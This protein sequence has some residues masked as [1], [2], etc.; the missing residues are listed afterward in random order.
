M[1]VDQ[2]FNYPLNIVLEVC[3]LPKETEWVEF[4]ENKADPEEIG[5]YISAL[6]NSAALA[7]KS[8]AY[9]VWGIEDITH[10]VVGTEFSPST[11]KVGN[12]ELESWLLRLLN[13]RI[14]FQFFEIEIEEKPVVLLEIE[15]A[16]RHPVQFKGMEYVR[17]GS[18]RKTLKDYPS[19]ERKL[20]RIFDQLSFEELVAKKERTGEEVL[21]LLDY[22]AYFSL[23][24]R[25]FPEAQKGVLETLASDGLIKNSD[26]GNWDIT[27]LGAILFAQRLSDFPLLR[28]KA[29]RVIHYR[30]S[31]RIETII[32]R[33]GEK[34]YA[35]GFLELISYIRSLLP[36]NE[37]MGQALR[38]TVLMY[39][40]L[41][42]RELVA[43]ALIHQDFFVKG[44]GPMVEIFSDRMEIS[45]P[46]EPLV[47]T[48]RFLDT[49]PKSRNEKL[50][51]LMRRFGIC[52][53]RGSGIDKVVFE[54]EL[55]QLP[56][57][58]FKTAIGNTLSIL[59]SYRPLTEM[60]K[61]DKIRACYL[62]SCLKYVSHDYMTNA[63]LRE[64][65]GIDDRNSAAAS[66]FIKEALDAGVIRAY[67]K[68]AGKRYMK[69]IPFWA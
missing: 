61:E 13:P 45:N 67:D 7:G 5:K 39:P 59:F 11:S 34:G 60:D 47:E 4:K 8:N 22:S 32:E 49:P 26:T 36:P 68:A 24:G 30:G 56:A 33:E 6:A 50:A 53:E 9:L 17:V 41:A 40:D 20:W 48:L 66:R 12:E 1:I 21:Q 16:F 15:K 35:S 57:P 43:N 18:Y 64:R 14:D 69:Y 37:M 23:S 2:Q 25:P 38:K 51:S 19:K 28:R 44:A 55:Y 46:G 10:Q 3:K 58:L 63:T 29:I 54:T 62:H 65:F 42:V 52:E 31:S 27:N